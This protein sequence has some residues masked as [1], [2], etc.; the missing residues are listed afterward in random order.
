MEPLLLIS[1]ANQ[2]KNVEKAIM[3]MAY[4]RGHSAGEDEVDSIAMGLRHDIYS[5]ILKDLR[6]QV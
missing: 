6:E 2:F 3:N 4:E 5:A 1:V